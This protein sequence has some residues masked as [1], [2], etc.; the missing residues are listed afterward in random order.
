[1]YMQQ[2]NTLT[3]LCSQGAMKGVVLVLGLLTSPEMRDHA[4]FADCDW[5]SDC[6]N[7][8]AKWELFSLLKHL[9]LVCICKVCSY[10]I[11]GVIAVSSQALT[12]LLLHPLQECPG[13]HDI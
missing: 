9:P 11:E 6:Q 7:D 3:L 10:A 2:S 8:P 4:L 5:V 12:H 1:M 13:L